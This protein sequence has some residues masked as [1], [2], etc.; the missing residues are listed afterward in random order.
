MRGL[1][2]RQANRHLTA[3]LKIGRLEGS[4][5]TRS[6]TASEYD[7]EGT[8]ALAASRARGIAVDGAHVDGILRDGVA[9]LRHVDAAGPAFDVTGAGTIPVVECGAGV[10]PCAS[11][12]DFDYDVTLPSS[13]WWEADA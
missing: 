11:A 13:R 9:M 12:L 5:L 4:L 10:S 7:L 2:V 1:I 3:R 6:P 8:T